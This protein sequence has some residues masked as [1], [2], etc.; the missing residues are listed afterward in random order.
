MFQEP[1]HIAGG[2]HAL[3]PLRVASEVLGVGSAEWIFLNGMLEE[4]ARR[5]A[6]E[7]GKGMVGNPPGGRLI[8]DEGFDG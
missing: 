5:G 2:F 6:W 8:L 3:L 7:I 1:H 4:G